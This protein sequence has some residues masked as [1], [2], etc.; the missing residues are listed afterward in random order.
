M[1]NVSKRQAER[2][3]RAIARA[4]GATYDGTTAGPVVRMEWS[5]WGMAP[6]TA[7]LWEGGDY[8]WPL[9]ATSGGWDEFG[10]VREPVRMPPGVRGEPLN[11][12]ALALYFEE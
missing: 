12:W 3:A 10:Q 11:S 8:D 2:I 7:I 5:A 9:L 1:R 6:V 4:N